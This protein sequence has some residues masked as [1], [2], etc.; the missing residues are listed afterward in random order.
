MDEAPLSAVPEPLKFSSAADIDD[1]IEHLRRFESG[2]MSPDEFKV[3]RLGRGTYGQRQ[4]NVNMIRVKIPQGV[5]AAAQLDRLADIG[6]EYSRG[7]G[8]IT[9]R[10][11]VQFHF[12]QLSRAAEVMT[13]LDEVGLTTKEACGSTVRN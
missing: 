6:D 13:K 3:Y 7:F 2:E 4:A 5:L 10:Q 9:T 1:F 8:H 12:V 11:N